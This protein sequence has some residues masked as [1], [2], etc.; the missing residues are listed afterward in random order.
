[1]ITLVLIHYSSVQGKLVCPNTEKRGEG[2][3]YGKASRKC[4]CKVIVEVEV[5]DLCLHA[6]DKQV[7]CYDL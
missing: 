2:E 5:W 6:S 7:D 4:P 3:I 1:M